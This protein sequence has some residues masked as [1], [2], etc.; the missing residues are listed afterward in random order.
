MANEAGHPLEGLVIPAISTS[1]GA[2]GPGAEKDPALFKA[3][4]LAS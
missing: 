2:F 1:S 4:I 3:P